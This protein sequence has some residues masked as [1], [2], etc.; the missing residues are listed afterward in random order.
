MFSRGPK[1]MLSAAVVLAAMADGQ[2]DASVVSTTTGVP[3]KPVTAKPDGGEE[4]ENSSGGGSS[5][6]SSTTIA[7]PLR[8]GCT[9]EYAPVCAG[10]AKTF[11]NLCTAESYGYASGDIKVGGPCVTGRSWKTRFWAKLRKWL[12]HQEHATNRESFVEQGDTDVFYNYNLEEKN[13]DAT[14]MKADEESKLAVYR[15]Q[16]GDNER[17]FGVSSSNAGESAMKGAGAD[18]KK[19]KGKGNIGE[20]GTD[21]YS[22]KEK[23]EY[24]NYNDMKKNKTA[25]MQHKNHDEMKEN[26]GKGKGDH[27]HNHEY[28][29]HDKKNKT[30]GWNRT[31]YEQK[32]ASF[33]EWKDLSYGAESSWKHGKQGKTNTTSASGFATTTVDKNQINIK[34]TKMKV[35]Q[36]K[37]F[38]Y[39]SMDDLRARMQ[40]V[41]EAHEHDVPMNQEVILR[42]KVELLESSLKLEEILRHSSQEW[43][44]LS[45]AEK[46]EV[47]ETKKLMLEERKARWN[48]LTEE[49]KQAYID[50]KK[51]SEHTGKGRGGKGGKGKGGKGED[52]KGKGKGAKGP[53]GKGEEGGDHED[54]TPATTTSTPS[55]EPTTTG[56]PSE[57]SSTTISVPAT[58]SPTTAAPE[59]TLSS[60]T[61]MLP[62]STP[63]SSTSETTSATSTTTAASPTFSKSGATTQ[64]LRRFLQPYSTGSSS[65]E[66]YDSSS[67]SKEGSATSYDWKN[68]YDQKD[69]AS[70]QMKGTSSSKGAKGISDQDT[71]KETAAASNRGIS[72]AE[73]ENS[74]GMKTS[75]GGKPGGKGS[76]SSSERA[77][78]KGGNTASASGEKQRPSSQKEGED[79]PLVSG[80]G[81]TIFPSTEA[82]VFGQM[83]SDAESKILNE[84]D[85]WYIADAEDREDSTSTRTNEK[86]ST[87]RDNTRSNKEDK[88]Y[89][90]TSVTT[91]YFSNPTSTSSS[92]NIARWENMLVT[93]DELHSSVPAPEERDPTLYNYAAF[94]TTYPVV[95]NGAEGN[96]KADDVETR[97]AMYGPAPATGVYYQRS[98]DYFEES[99]EDVA[100]DAAGRPRHVLWLSLVVAVSALFLF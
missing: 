35:E 29:H 59:S 34:D 94:E 5:T 96:D 45:E 20:Q 37:V 53:G 23:G 21:I 30:E 89:T 79:A 42:G 57:S 92:S 39:V 41:D 33:K 25:M 31:A 9:R 70:S 55:E 48:S 7:P 19:G 95:T 11:P 80:D 43:K 28:D 98:E 4:Q 51:A 17:I 44:N 93:D 83:F 78:G 71:E 22:G 68:S 86:D 64:V 85:G 75:S 18:A 84:R 61:T 10:G 62:A 100:N 73:W 13:K 49:E 63:A 97:T 60:T 76:S 1:V 14:A 26:K 56:S 69:A 54:K 47:R 77:P 24:N 15:A 46:A 67:S 65:K 52:G 6:S 72:A 88:D 2:E 58:T 66:S 27:H 87:T 32:W 36:E 82:D 50:K 99:D 74:S 40:A 8:K 12:V 38:P 3:M 90:G 81:R 91:T 16:E